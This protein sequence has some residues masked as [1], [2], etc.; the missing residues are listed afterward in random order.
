MRT[1]FLPLFRCI[2]FNRLVLV[3]A[4]LL[5]IASMPMRASAQAPSCLADAD[6]TIAKHLGGSTCT[7]Q[8][9]KVAEAVNP[10]NADGTPITTCFAGTQFSFIAD[11]EVVTN[12]TARENVGFY[13]RTDGITPS[14]ANSKCNPSDSA[15]YQYCN[16][17]EFSGT[18]VDNI[19]SPLHDPGQATQ[20]SCVTSGTGTQC[21]GSA[22]Y[23]ED[24]AT[25]KNGQADNCGDTHSATSPQFVT[26]AVNNIVCP[27][28]GTQFL[29][30]N[31][32]TWWQ[33]TDTFPACLSPSSQGWP[34]EPAAIAGTTS[35]CNCSAVSVPI[36]PISITA[37]AQKACTTSITTGGTAG[38]NVSPGNQSPVLCDEGPESGNAAP[39][40]TVGITPSGTAPSG[41]TVVVDQICDNQY[42]TVY[43]DNLMNS[44]TPPARVF[45][46]CPAGISKLTA[47][48]VS[49]PP[50]DFSSGTGTCTFTTASLGTELSSLTDTVFASMHVQSS[51]GALLAKTTTSNSNQVKVYT[52]EAQTTTTTGKLYNS[53]VGACATVRYN[54]TVAD[55]SIAEESVTLSTLSD[56][57]YGNITACTNASCANTGGLLVLGTNCL[58]GA[59]VGTL[60]N[61]N[62]TLGGTNVTT[63]GSVIIPGG[64][65]YTCQFDGQFCSGNTPPGGSPITLT[66]GCMTLKDTVTSTQAPDE[67]LT[68]A[69]CEDSTGKTIPCTNLG[70]TGSATVQECIAGTPQ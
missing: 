7:A 22:A 1:T 65:N 11:F 37:S 36:T 10:R 12:A 54:V 57:V 51:T 45:P 42:G 14:G 63:A 24:T 13:M 67:S 52:D 8:D 9:V 44:A 19:V 5:A 43:D 20:V 30:P 61:T 48:N 32:T 70:T 6:S 55:S 40:Y 31:C 68:N 27:A 62:A 35:K 66:N 34:W 21:L 41:T 33:P 18:C 23:S 3:S 4:A 59:G 50:T 56:N 16:A 17:A 46:P 49:C 47:T 64:G 53:T 29:L 28:V 58:L 39:T 60:A 38:V 15:T 69:V 26:I 25:L 2:S